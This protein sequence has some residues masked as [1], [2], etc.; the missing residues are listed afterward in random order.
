MVFA[1]RQS[2]FHNSVFII[3]DSFRIK[4]KIEFNDR[5]FMDLS[6][7]NSIYF[8]GIGGI[9]ISAAAGLAHC[10]HFLVSGSDAVETES[11]RDLRLHQVK[12][13]VPHDA[14]NITN[15]ISLVVY[16]VAVPES[17]PELARAKELNIPTLTYPQFL[18]LLMSDKFGV[19]IA[20]TDGKTTTTAMLAK[21]LIDAGTDPS[22]V[23]GSR[24][25]FLEDNWRCGEGRDKYFVFEADEYRRA[26]A[27]YSPRLAIITNIGVDHLDYY[28]DETDYLNA[29]QAYLNKV[30]ADGFAIINRDDERSLIASGSIQ[31]KVVT[32]S[33]GQPAD[34][35]VSEIE[36]KDGRQEFVVMENGEAK[37]MITLA[38]PGQYNVA[39]A[40]AAIAAA[41]TLGIGWDDIAKSLDGYKGIWRRFE[42]LGHLGEATIIADYAHTPGGVSQAI[43]ATQDFFPNKNILMVFQPHQYART[44]NL[45]EGFVSAFDGAKKVLLPDIFYVVGREK[46]EDFDV[47]SVK[48]AEEVKSR[49]VDVVAS[50]DLKATEQMIRDLAGDYDV[51]LLLGAGDIYE[52][53]K[54][55]VK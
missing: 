29:F 35:S 6:K 32:F 39:N 31:A 46:P 7:V 11:V 4:C 25:E 30:P 21:I 23:L 52:V 41:R 9:G 1:A 34:F 2:V 48:L 19:G 14:D 17:N 20:G 28:E 44:K 36:V 24:A 51:I 53:A 22:V 47:S 3:H 37:K 54:N 42:T 43:K 49:G 38:L 18:G 55:L 10:R 33:V 12:V 5:L 27:N 45:F 50:G 8:I 13:N 16:S 15:D 26:F 40:L